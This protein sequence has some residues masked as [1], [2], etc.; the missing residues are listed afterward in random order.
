MPKV[1]L[2]DNPFFGISHLTPEKSY[3]YLKDTERFDKAASIINAAE[4]IGIDTFMVSSHSDTRELLEAA[5]YGTNAVLPDI[6]LVVPNVHKVNEHAAAKGLV[7]ALKSLFSD[8]LN[9]SN[10]R[11]RQLYRRI[12]MGDIVYPKTKY[13]ALHNVVVDM[14]VG[15]HGHR[16][17][18]LFC[19]VTR[20]FGF[21]PV[22]ITLNPVRLMSLGIRCSAVCCYY[23][24]RGYNMCDTPEAML[25]TFEES[26]EVEEIW[27]MGILASG[28]VS[29]DEISDDA[30][31][32]SFTRV[33]VASSRL[34]RIEEMRRLF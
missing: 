8:G 31:L 14:L 17:L 34:D 3:E 24:A 9:F 15:L 13:V 30:L 21:K 16:A 11:P 10:L 25:K 5:G 4:G 23:N 12:V 18:S 19:R 22:L 32:N 28:A 2:G 29:Y 7:G 26:P 27:A 1:I 33:I 6:C 20:L